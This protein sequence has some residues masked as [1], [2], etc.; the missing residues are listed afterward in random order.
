MAEQ[1]EDEH[2]ALIHRLRTVNLSSNADEVI[3]LCHEAADALGRQRGR[4]LIKICR[5]VYD[6]VAL[7]G[8]AA[9]PS[10]KP[11]QLRQKIIGAQ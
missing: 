11:R 1:S 5:I 8:G 7:P 2:T 10:G 4:D 3:K 9:P 6:C